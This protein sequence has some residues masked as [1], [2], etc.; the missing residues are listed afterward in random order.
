MDLPVESVLLLPDAEELVDKVDERPGEPNHEEHHAP[1][2]LL[3]DR[4]PRKDE[5]HE[6]ERCRDDGDVAL[7]IANLLDYENKLDA[8]GDE[9]EKVKLEERHVDLVVEVAAF[10]AAVGTNLVVDL[11][12]KLFPHVPAEHDKSDFRN[13]D[14]DRYRA[15]K[16]LNRDGLGRAF[17]DTISEDASDFRDLDDGVDEEAGVEDDETNDENRVA[18][19]DRV[20]GK[21]HLVAM[22]DG[23]DN[24]KHGERA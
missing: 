22:G 17:S 18:V 11:P 7:R 14:H 8:K 23:E 19:D 3:A 16:Y 10:E 20:D 5:D 9:D 4:V 2:E 21:E 1:P 24:D 6:A 12:A 13:A 15:S